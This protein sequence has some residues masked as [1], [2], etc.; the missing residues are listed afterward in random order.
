MLMTAGEE[1]EFRH[2]AQVWGGCG[3]TVTSPV[4]DVAVGRHEPIRLL[5]GTQV[6]KG[7]TTR[8]VQLNFGPQ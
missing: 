1:A 6:I 5:S 2:P 8:Q 3:I 7:S 4:S